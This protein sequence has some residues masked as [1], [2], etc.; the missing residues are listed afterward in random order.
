MKSEKEIVYELDKENRKGQ[1][2]IDRL[3]I[4]K[5]TEAPKALEEEAKVT[6]KAA[7]IMENKGIQDKV[8][9][10]YEEISNTIKKEEQLYVKQILEGNSPH[11]DSV[12]Y[13]TK[14]AHKYIRDEEGNYVLRDE[15]LVRAVA[16][17]VSAELVAKSIEDKKQEAKTDDKEKDE[18]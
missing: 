6:R 1:A 3:V 9:D 12:D 16:I 5:S 17:Q 11:K 10:L 14:N 15:Y 7:K 2:F 18:K 8:N 4:E 13:Y